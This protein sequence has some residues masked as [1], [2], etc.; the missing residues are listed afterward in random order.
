M[1]R[2]NNHR[3]LTTYEAGVIAE[4]EAE[5]DEQRK[6][7]PV[8]SPLSLQNFG[9]TADHSCGGCF[10]EFG[11][12]L[13]AVRQAALPGGTNGSTSLSDSGGLRP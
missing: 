3:S 8:N 4:L 2:K 1:L 10:P 12:Q 11:D 6:E 13:K 7:L 9:G 5:I